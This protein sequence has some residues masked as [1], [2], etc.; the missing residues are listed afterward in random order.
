M[1]L[2][3]SAERVRNDVSQV[4]NL[5]IETP[6]GTLY[7]TVTEDEIN[8]QIPAPATPKAAPPPEA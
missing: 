4:H 2:S 5:P 3:S 6:L 1:L 7:V 8:L